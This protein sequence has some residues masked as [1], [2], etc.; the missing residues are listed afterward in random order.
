MYIHVHVHAYKLQ[1][2]SVPAHHYSTEVTSFKLGNGK[3][4]GL[5]H[6]G[7][8]PLSQQG[9]E[10]DGA[11]EQLRGGERSQEEKG[12]GRE[13]RS[14]GEREGGREREEGGRE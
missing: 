13:G 2:I 6:V 1:S 5:E 8:Q 9:V 10:V 12:G 14:E 11:A 3:I 7:T 4:N